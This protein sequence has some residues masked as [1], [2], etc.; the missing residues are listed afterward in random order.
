MLE[1]V[2]FVSTCDEKEGESSQSSRP[3]PYLSHLCQGVETRIPHLHHLLLIPIATAA[4][5]PLLQSDPEAFHL[6][7]PP[8]SKHLQPFS[9]PLFHQGQRLAA[10]HLSVRPLAPP[11]LPAH[12]PPLLEARLVAPLLPLRPLRWPFHR[13]AGLLVGHLGAVEGAHVL[14]GLLDVLRDEVRGE[15]HRP[16][17]RRPWRCGPSW[18]ASPAPPLAVY[19]S[20][21]N[22]M[23]ELETLYS[24]RLQCEGGWRTLRLTCTLHAFFLS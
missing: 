22:D 19:R 21:W 4:I 7:I 5:I 14:L 18:Q 15:A 17:P 2:C 1:Y 3:A 23:H 11:L 20:S 8:L 24:P 16:C 6:Q 9:T 12:P 10:W 13:L